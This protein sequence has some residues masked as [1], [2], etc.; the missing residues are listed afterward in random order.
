MSVPFAFRCS[1]PS[2][3]PS[4]HRYDILMLPSRARMKAECTMMRRVKKS[5]RE[6][7]RDT[8]RK[9]GGVNFA[10]CLIQWG[11]RVRAP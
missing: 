3:R 8:H 2:T 6:V 11:P 5:T 1:V 10:S 7:K 9:R 4:T